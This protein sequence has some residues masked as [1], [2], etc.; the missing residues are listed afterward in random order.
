MAMVALVTVAMAV[1]VLDTITCIF[2]IFLIA[3]IW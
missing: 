1:V 2:K 3:P